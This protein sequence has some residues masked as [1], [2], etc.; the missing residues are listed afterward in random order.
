[1][2]QW[3]LEQRCVCVCSATSVGGKRCVRVCVFSVQATWFWC[4]RLAG[5]E[6]E[7]WLVGGTV[8]WYVGKVNKTFGVRAR[9]PFYFSDDNKKMTTKL[10]QPR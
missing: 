9:P 7:G 10:T 2:G 3:G 1:M 5:R 4:A 8:G 6:R